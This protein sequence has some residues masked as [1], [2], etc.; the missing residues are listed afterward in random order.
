[1]KTGHETPWGPAT[2]VAELAP[3]IEAVTTADHGGI[4]LD[5]EHAAK[6]TSAIGLGQAQWFE[7][8][9]DWCI[10]YVLFAA[11]I[12]EHGSDHARSII[13]R[14]IHRKCLKAH[15][16]QHF[17]AIVAASRH[18][19]KQHKVGGTRAENRQNISYDYDLQVWLRDGFIEP[20]GHAQGA[21]R[22][23]ACVCAGLTVAQAKTV[24]RAGR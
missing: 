9:C 17:D 10:P 13:A 15:H 4:H 21:N 22:C 14:D 16:G 19:R 12:N 23:A 18:D 8:D 5:A 7:E 2:A 20:C 11:E 3:G 24:R 6:V 1:M